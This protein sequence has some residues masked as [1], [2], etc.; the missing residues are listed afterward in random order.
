MIQS[1]LSSQTDSQSKYNSDMEIGFLQ[2]M[3]KAF[4]V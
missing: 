2:T 4:K 1:V 3:N